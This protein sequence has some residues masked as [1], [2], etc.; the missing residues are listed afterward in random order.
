MAEGFKIAAAHL[1]PCFMDPMASARKAAE[2][3]AKAGAEGV[4]LLVFPEVFLPGFPYW[5]NL[6]PPLI[7]AP[8]NRRYQDASVEIGGP[9]I[10]IVREAAAAAGVAVVMG[11]SERAT[12]GRTCYNSAIFIESDGR[13]LGVHRKLKPTYAERYIWG[14]GDGSTLSVFDS[15]VGRLGGLACWEHTMNLA[16]QALIEDGEQIHAALWPSL[17][18]MAGFDAVANIQIEAMMRN[19]AITGQTFVV[20][21]S[22]PVD[23]QV[24]DFLEKEMG[25][26]QLLVAGG[27]WSAV[28]HPFAATLAGPVSGEGDQLLIAD[29]DLGAIADTKLW[30]DSIGHYSR[31]D[32]L[33]LSIDRSSRSGPIEQGA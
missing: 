27:G 29:V 10:A 30:V 1:A 7:Q 16:R 25:P 23:G 22:S 21:A 6:Y 4:R 19:H 8:M 14:E 17:S 28:I 2:W 18:T 9:E 26:Q 15:S 33:R 12:G 13:L 3:I 5:I 11:A 20:C 31:P 32:V 24:L